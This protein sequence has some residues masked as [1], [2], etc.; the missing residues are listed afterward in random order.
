VGL[1]PG[2]LE[3]VV[4]SVDV[5]LGLGALGHAG[6]SLGH[7]GN[8]GGRTALKGVAERLDEAR[9]IRVEIVIVHEE[10]LADGLLFERE[11]RSESV[12]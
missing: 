12:R 5:Q 10:G 9:T 3:G 11:T 4:G 2:Q 1:V 6:T 7:E 8:G